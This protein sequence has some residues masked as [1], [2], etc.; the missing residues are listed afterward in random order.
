MIQEYIEKLDEK[1][2]EYFK[3]E[4]KNKKL[5]T[6][7]DSIDASNKETFLAGIMEFMANNQ[8]FLSQILSREISDSFWRN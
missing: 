1:S 2:D 7:F 6:Y 4:V 5:P 8:N 3:K